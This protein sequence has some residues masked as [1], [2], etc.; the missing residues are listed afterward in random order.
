M[1]SIAYCRSEMIQSVDLITAL[2]DLGSSVGEAKT[3]LESSPALELTLHIGSRQDC[4]CSAQ[5]RLQNR[6]E[7]RNAPGDLPD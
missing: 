3:F 7:L 1:G 6:T 4:E 2:M 5:V